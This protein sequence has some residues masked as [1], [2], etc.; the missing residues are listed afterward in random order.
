MP[1][2][3]VAEDAN[4][5]RVAHSPGQTRPAPRSL[6]SGL[7]SKSAYSL[8]RSSARV[9]F[10][11]N[12]SSIS[13]CQVA[14]RA[15]SAAKSSARPRRNAWRRRFSSALWRISNLCTAI[16]SL[17][18]AR[19]HCALIIAQGLAPERQAGEYSLTLN[20]GVRARLPASDLVARRSRVRAIG[21]DWIREFL[22]LE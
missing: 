5:R 6:L 13:S 1:R 12:L 20:K 18:S 21:I 19:I 11:A 7:G 9:W 2:R 8:S 3:P 14:P 22:M 4:K 15:R 10:H 16:S 17:S